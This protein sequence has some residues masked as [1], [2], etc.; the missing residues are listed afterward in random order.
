MMSNI[1][2]SIVNHKLNIN[3]V[4][5]IKWKFIGGMEY[6]VMLRYKNT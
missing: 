4:L 6:F 3:V 5:C 1:V 2:N